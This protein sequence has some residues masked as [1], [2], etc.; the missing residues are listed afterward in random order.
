MECKTIKKKS[1]NRKQ[2]S[3]IEKNQKKI[4]KGSSKKIR[5][6]LVKEVVVMVRK[7]IKEQQQN[8]EQSWNLKIKQK[9]AIESS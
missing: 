9:I 6:K 5:K 1:S 7:N 3:W 4:S 2:Q 8:V